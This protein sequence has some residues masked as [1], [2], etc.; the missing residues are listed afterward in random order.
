MTTHSS[1]N[2][3]GYIALISVLIVGAASLA[4]GLT[5]LV[6]GTDAQRETLVHQQSVQARNLATACIEEGLEQIHDSTSY[7]GTATVTLTTGSCSYTVTNTGTTTRTVDASSTVGNVV[8][9]AKTYATIS[10]SS[11]SITSWQDVQ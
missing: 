8:R 2:Q 9:K 10:S 6:T 3:S 11:I 4:V 1:T 7:T 5:L